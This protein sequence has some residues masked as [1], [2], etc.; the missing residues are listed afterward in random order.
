MISLEKASEISRHLLL[1]TA[2]ES[3]DRQS[4]L[5]LI[6]EL[7]KLAD[8]QRF[9]VVKVLYWSQ[10]SQRVINAIF[11][12]FNVKATMNWDFGLFLEYLLKLSNVYPRRLS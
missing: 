6:E 8:Q 4:S 9:T 2:A 3:D 11:T 12:K 10:N 1:V 5:Q 7:L